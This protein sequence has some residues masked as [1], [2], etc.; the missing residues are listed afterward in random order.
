MDRNR[1]PGVPPIQG[2]DRVGLVVIGCSGALE[3]LWLRGGAVLEQRRPLA[4][5]QV[6]VLVVGGRPMV[7]A[8]GMII[9][10]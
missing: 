10:S 7:N 4:S 3:T 5:G 9:G 8:L 2:V 6:R 1:R